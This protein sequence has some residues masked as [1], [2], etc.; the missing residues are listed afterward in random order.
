M[1]NKRFSITGFARFYR[2]LPRF[3][4]DISDS[5]ALEM[6]YSLYTAVNDTYRYKNPSVHFTVYGKNDFYEFM[7]QTNYKPYR[8]E[9]QLYRAMEALYFYKI[10][11]AL[12]IEQVKSVSTIGFMMS[13]TEFRFYKAFDMEI[14]DGR[15]IYKMCARSLV[16][17]SDEP[18]LC[19]V[20]D[21]LDALTANNA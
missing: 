17:R 5:Q 6:T 20:Q 8:T 3:H 7:K 18:G 19:L 15:T 16:P 21:W 12:K 13:D 2:S 10:L 14:D 9:I 4:R 11:D 1:N